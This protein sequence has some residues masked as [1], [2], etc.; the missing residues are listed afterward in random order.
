MNVPYQTITKQDAIRILKG[1]G[2][3]FVSARIT[4]DDLHN[5]EVKKISLINL[6]TRFD[7]SVKIGYS[8]YIAGEDTYLY[9]EWIN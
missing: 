8:A 7:N 2:R 6:V 4:A 1:P 9:F 5:I 3:A